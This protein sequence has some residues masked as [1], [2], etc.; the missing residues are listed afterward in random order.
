MAL[1]IALLER[2]RRHLPPADFDRLQEQMLRRQAIRLRETALELQGL[3]IKLGQFLSTRVD[4]LPESFTHELAGLRDLVPPVP[5]AAAHAQIE[6]EFA[7]PLATVFA[8]IDPQPLASASLG[9]THRAVL[10]DGRIVAVKVQRPGVE[11]L[12]AIDLDAVKTVVRLA[13]RWT[14]IDRRVDLMAL[15]GELE[16]TTGEELD[17]VQEAAYAEQFAANF[18]QQNDVVVPAVHRDVSTRRVLVM[19]F[20][21]GHPVDDRAALLAAGLRPAEVAERIVRT[22]LQQVLRD[23]FFHADPHPGNVFVAFDGRL[24]YLD[25]GM[26]GTITP[27]DRRAMGRFV[28]GVIRRDLEALVGAMRDLGFLRPHAD[29]ETLKRGLTVVLDRLS[30]V[31][32]SQPNSA[33]F[34]EFLDDMR[35]FLRSEPFQIPTQYAFLGRAV[36]ILLGVTSAL[37]PKIDLVKLLRE[38]ALRYLDPAA[39]EGAGAA[40]GLGGV[41]WQRIASEARD[42][43][44]LLYRL[45]HRIDRLLERAENGDLRVRIDLGTVGRRL[46]ERNRVLERLVRAV[47]TLGA[48]GAATALLVGGRAGDA[49]IGWGVTA[50][51][52]LWTLLAGRGAGS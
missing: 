3:L 16:R 38:H 40:A 4:V 48:A 1:E 29:A 44:L 43:G 45:P 35:E 18:E 12:I 27:S 49:H 34:Q 47:L 7:R 52:L 32:L 36:G 37:D 10:L 6:R 25:F 8:D 50:V 17:Y 5:W 39:Q 28:S 26:M 41:D 46:D 2:R 51:L 13:R 21:E 31:P 19:E 15:Y 14:S 20:M 42:L 9:Q 33:E 11:E 23:G 24:I 22:Y 30:G